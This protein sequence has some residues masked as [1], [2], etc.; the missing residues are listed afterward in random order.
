MT[1]YKGVQRGGVEACNNWDADEKD[2]VERK[3]YGIEEN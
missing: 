1:G 3:N 2:P